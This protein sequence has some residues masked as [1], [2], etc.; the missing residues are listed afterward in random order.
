MLVPYPKVPEPTGV[1][2]VSQPDRLQEGV[3]ALPGTAHGWLG[4]AL[5]GG[6]APLCLHV[7]QRQGHRREICAQPLH[8]P[9]GVQ[10]R[11]AGYAQ[12]AAGVQLRRT[13]STRGATHSSLPD[14]PLSEPQQQLVLPFAH[15]IASS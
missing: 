13:E 10:R 6:A 12:G 14:L 15:T 7:Q 4:Q 9:G 5:R 8:G 11:P 3:L 1:V 2:S